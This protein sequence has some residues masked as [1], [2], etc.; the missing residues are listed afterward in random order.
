MKRTLNS[1]RSTPNMPSSA[2]VLAFDFGERFVGVAVGDTETRLAH[3]VG[4]FEASNDRQRLA[5]IEPLVRDWRPARLVVGLP[6]ALDGSEHLMTA[7]VRRFARRLAGRFAMAVD[8]SDERLSSTCAEETLR[9]A[10]RGGRRHKREAH[11]LAASLILQSY[12][13]ENPV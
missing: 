9:A 11:A 12:L 4:C 8:F 3:P 1:E 7:R 6:F 2:T 13:D 10:G 5:K